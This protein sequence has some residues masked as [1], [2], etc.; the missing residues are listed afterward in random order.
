MNGV[1][2]TIN[3][4]D[5]EVRDDKWT[6]CT[7]CRQLYNEPTTLPCL[8][9]FC[10][11]CLDDRVAASRGAHAQSVTCPRCRDAFPLPVGGLGQLPVNTFFARLTERRRDQTGEVDSILIVCRQRYA[12]CVSL[13]TP[14]F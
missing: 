7:V 1:G 6:T 4:G 2:V 10:R 8:H 13:F 11:R 3:G 9:T 12:S 5:K 14:S